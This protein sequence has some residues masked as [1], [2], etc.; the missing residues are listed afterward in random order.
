MNLQ[1]G[2]GVAWAMRTIPRFPGPPVI[3]TALRLKS[4]P[5][6]L[7]S[8]ARG[9][10]GDIV[11]MNVGPESVLCISD[12][13]LLQEVIVDKPQVYV[14]S[15]RAHTLIREMFGNG[16]K[17]PTA[18]RAR[19]SRAVATDDTC[20]DRDS[21]GPLSF[22]KATNPDHSN[23]CCSRPTTP[24]TAD[25][26]TAPFSAVL[27]IGKGRKS[28]GRTDKDNSRKQP[29]KCHKQV[30]SHKQKRSRDIQKN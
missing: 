6:Q 23:S 4:N 15:T 5:L 19:T 27:I 14:R 17:L 22:S 20:S 9:R 26:V 12:P 13:L 7:L 21:T 28:G 30:T 2:A 1:V 11:R 16:L 25:S 18:L 8:E 24:E 29:A 10:Y 3:G